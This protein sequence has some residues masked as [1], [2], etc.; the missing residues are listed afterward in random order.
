MKIDWLQGLLA[1][2]CEEG[3][4]GVE[5]FSDMIS[6]SI[7]FRWLHISVGERCPV[8]SSK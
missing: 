7:N 2:A 3:C 5:E 1:A 4:I 8:V 6:C